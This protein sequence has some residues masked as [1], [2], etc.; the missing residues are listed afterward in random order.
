DDNT[1]QNTAQ[2]PD[3]SVPS[4][5]QQTGTR[6]RECAG[7]PDSLDDEPCC[8]TEGHQSV[9]GFQQARVSVGISYQQWGCLFGPR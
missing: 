8:Y 5:V 6:S 4:N 1:Q 9:L 2:Y 7:R 3:R